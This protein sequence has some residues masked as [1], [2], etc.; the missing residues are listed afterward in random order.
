MF[1]CDHDEIKKIS[2]KHKIPVLHDA[3]HSFGSSYKGKMIG[4]QHDYTIFSFDPVKTITCIDGGAIVVNGSANVKKL[5]AKRLIGMTQSAQRMYKNTRA[6]EYDI[7][8]IGFR[9]H[10]AILH[11]AIG[12]QQLKK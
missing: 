5:H 9:Y 10:L 4:N 7:N 6:W 12:I 11:A 3:A 1:L 8:E 2:N